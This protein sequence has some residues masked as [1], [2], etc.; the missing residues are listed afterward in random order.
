MEIK[1]AETA[2]FCFGVNRAVNMVYELL[3]KNEKVCTLGPIIHNPQLV[4]E[5]ADRGV[6]IVESPDEVA[7]SE[8]L[9]IRS[10]GVAKSVYDRAEEL[11]IKIADATCPFVAKIHKIVRE[12]SRNGCVTIIAGDSEHQ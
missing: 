6:R 12:N 9:V 5:L 7:E 10:H 4:N 1:L 11:G 8:T 3:D 2:G